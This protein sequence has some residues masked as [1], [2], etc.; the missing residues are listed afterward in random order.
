MS[1][2][3]AS[4]GRRSS[5]IIVERPIMTRFSRKRR[6]ACTSFEASVPALGTSRSKT[7]LFL[8]VLRNGIVR[9]LMSPRSLSTATI[10]GDGFASGWVTVGCLS[11]SLVVNRHGAAQLDIA[12]SPPS[13]LATGQADGQAN[14]DG[15]ANEM[16][17]S[18]V[19][20]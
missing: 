3:D 2:G 9:K 20:N 17:G 13:S 18:S 7:D 10:K 12:M 19:R 8:D 15:L 1:A 14:V 6:S 4:A 16:V 5:S 11:D